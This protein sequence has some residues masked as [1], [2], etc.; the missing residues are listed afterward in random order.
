MKKSIFVLTVL[1][2]VQGNMRAIPSHSQHVLAAATVAASCA[3]AYCG[4]WLKEAEFKQ[5]ALFTGLT[6]AAAGLVWYV[7]NKYTPEGKFDWANDVNK[8][9]ERN[10]LIKE[11]FGSAQ[12]LEAYVKKRF[13][14][15]KWPIIEAYYVLQ[16]QH[17]DALDGVVYLEQAQEERAYDPLFVGRAQ[18]LQED[19]CKK[20]E[21]ICVPLMMIREL[22]Y[23]FER[24]HQYEMIKA[25][26]AK[27]RAQQDMASSQSQMAFNSYWRR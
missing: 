9:I 25:E 26:Q 11:S 13:V 27:A 19:L 12:E 4:E 20:I 10:G 2:A 8:R 3:A 17:N 7:V 22:P 24:F 5:M 1:L 14:R 15:E 23:F 21:L 16:G 18:A 6:G